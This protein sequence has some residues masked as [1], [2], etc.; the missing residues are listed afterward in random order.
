LVVGIVIA[1]LVAL[2]MLGARKY[3]RILSAP[4]LLELAR[5]LDRLK[6]TAFE[7]PLADPAASPDPEK[8]ALVSSAGVVL[9][10]TVRGE[11]SAHE[12]HLSL[13]YRGGPL[14]YGAAGTVIV[15]LARALGVAIDRIRLGRSDQGVYHAGFTL[16]SE[17]HE[18]LRAA[19]VNVPA[20][21]EVPAQLALCLQDARRMGPVPR[22]ATP[23][24]EERPGR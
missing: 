15:F 16:D 5:G 1:L 7:H 23:K 10:Y 17:A 22:I 19:P 13:S 3:E 6:T 20:A 11:G 8:H 21:E 12:H 2:M 24:P 9:C 14:A 4:H 18:A